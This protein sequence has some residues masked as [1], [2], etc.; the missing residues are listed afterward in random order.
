MVVPVIVPV[1]VVVS[2]PCPGVLLS[3]SCVVTT[4]RP[5]LADVDPLVTSPDV[6]MYGGVVLSPVSKV[7]SG[8][9]LVLVEVKIVFA[10][11]VNVLRD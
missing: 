1:S 10:V 9:K 7:F 11:S 5:D 8:T 3:I 6:L 2:A 4:A